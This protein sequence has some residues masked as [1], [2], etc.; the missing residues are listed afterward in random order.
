M[1][2]ALRR[3]ESKFDS[4]FDSAES[5]RKGVE[6]TIADGSVRDYLRDSDGKVQ[7]RTYLKSA[8]DPSE[9]QGLGTPIAHVRFRAKVVRWTFRSVPIVPAI[10]ALS[11]GSVCSQATPVR[12]LPTFIAI[13]TY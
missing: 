5:A 11:I 3:T 8:L 13:R 10:F 4:F 6:R 7:Q 9:S 12:T 1:W 2:S